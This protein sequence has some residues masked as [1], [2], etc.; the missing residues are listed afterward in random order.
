MS[1]EL[2]SILVALKSQ[3]LKPELYVMGLMG[4]FRSDSDGLVG[5]PCALG[6][7]GGC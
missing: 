6:G 5:R 1:N 4:S 3:L 7:T 2:F